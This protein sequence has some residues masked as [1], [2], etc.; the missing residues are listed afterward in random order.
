MIYDAQARKYQCEFVLDDGWNVD[1]Q[2][3]SNNNVRRKAVLMPKYAWRT[4]RNA[5]ERA[6]DEFLDWDFLQHLIWLLDPTHW[7]E[8]VQPFVIWNDRDKELRNW[9]AEADLGGGAA[10][11]GGLRRVIRVH[12]NILGLGDGTWR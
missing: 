8:K 3:E 12:D 5:C 6:K 7:H 10:C 11:L 4:I 2:V 1:L 9:N